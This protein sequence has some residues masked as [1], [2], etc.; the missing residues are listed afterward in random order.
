M[1]RSVVIAALLALASVAAAP[2]DGVA[3]AGELRAADTQAFDYPTVQA[4]LRMGAIVEARTNGRYTIKVFHSR[5]LG[6]E[7]ETIE[8]TRVGAIDINRSSVGPFQS[9]VPAAGVLA[10]PFLFRSPDHLHKVIDGPIGKEILAAFEPYGFM[11]LAYYDAGARSLYNSVRPIHD[12]EDLKGLKIRVQQSDQTIAAMEALG[13]VAVALPYGQVQTALVTGLVDGAENNWPSYISTD[14]YKAAHYLTLTEHSMSPEVVVMSLKAW[15]ALSP[16][17]Q[18]IF[19]EAAEESARFM[20][21]EWE[22]REATARQTAAEAGVAVVE[23]F[24]K[25]SFAAAM[26]PVYDRFVTDP[27][28][29]DLVERIRKVE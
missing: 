22:A 6:E 24:D 4:L 21:A 27:V 15:H 10:L 5:Q 17:D 29:K 18:T 8:Q 16:T 26:Q 20:R 9:F 11:G 14:H 13:A 28:L 23:T 12:L 7:K 19:R 3:E 2:R 25:K 1:L